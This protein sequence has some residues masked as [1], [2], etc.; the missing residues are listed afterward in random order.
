MRRLI[1]TI[2]LSLL[3]CTHRNEVVNNQP[4]QVT[5]VPSI[6]KLHFD[7]QWNY[8][9]DDLLAS[10]AKTNPELICLEISK[11]AFNGPLEG[12]YPPEAALL[13]EYFGTKRIPVVPADWRADRNL[14][15]EPSQAFEDSVRGPKDEFKK[16][17]AD[18][19]DKVSFL[20]SDE[21]KRLVKKIHSLYI[22]QLGEAADGFWNTRNEKIA[23]SC[24]REATK[25]GLVRVSVIFG[26]DHF[27]ALE[28]D[29]R[30]FGSVELR[31]PEI[32]REKSESNLP[33][34]A[35]RRWTRNLEN[36]EAALNAPQADEG[37]RRWIKESN[38]IDELK[39]FIGKV[40]QRSVP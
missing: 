18:K 26:I 33:Q 35:L 36:L 6:H 22:E 23:G 30:Q 12:L 28:E 5:L 13:A 19:K 20:I 29:F 2:L 4:L 21:G 7:S 25:L 40:S 10:V 34:L 8:T 15:K 3:G 9:L 17:L 11:E 31:M 27:Y 1:F 39:L 24:Y 16:R 38:R 37:I 14:Y 32:R